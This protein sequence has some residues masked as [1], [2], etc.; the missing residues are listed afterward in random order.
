[1]YYVW[2]RATVPIGTMGVTITFPISLGTIYSG[3]TVNNNRNYSGFTTYNNYAVSGTWAAN[4][5]IMADAQ[6][7]STVMVFLIG[8]TQWILNS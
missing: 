4:G 8:V 3:G 5:T 1:M 6:Y 2:A 7:A